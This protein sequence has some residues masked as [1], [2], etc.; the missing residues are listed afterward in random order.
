MAL[1]LLA[2]VALV[3][4]RADEVVARGENAIALLRSAGD[5]VFLANA[6]GDVGLYL[7]ASGDTARG[8][9]F[10]DDAILLDRARGDRYLEGVRLSDRGIIAH[11]VG[12]QAKAMR[13]YAES[14]RLLADVGGVWYLASP[15]A[16]LAALSVSHDAARAARL[17]G[18]AAAL[19]ERGGIAGWPTERER[20]EHATATARA[21]LGP[22]VFAHEFA[23]G[24]KL[25]AAEVVAEA[26]ASTGRPESPAPAAGT[27]TPREEDVLRL[28]VAGRSDREIAA[29]LFISPRTASKHVGAILAKLNATSRGEAA[30]LAVRQGLV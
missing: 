15:C 18:A 23:H 11:D 3:E 8:A 17:L 19:R 24:R 16:G 30:V 25:A 14:A 7:A 9:A 10:I 27:L 5:E 12:D 2:Y 4:G 21:I 13:C 26:L 20:D 28:L 6:L 1:L 29:A 22:A